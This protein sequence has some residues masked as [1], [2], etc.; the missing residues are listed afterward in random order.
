MK[1]ATRRTSTTL[2]IQRIF[3]LRPSAADQKY[4]TLANEWKRVLRLIF[5]IEYSFNFI[6]IEKHNYIFNWININ[7]KS[8]FL[9]WCGRFGA[10]SLISHDEWVSWESAPI[11][12]SQSFFHDLSIRVSFTSQNPNNF[13][14]ECN[15]DYFSSWNF[16]E[17]AYVCLSVRQMN[18][19]KRLNSC[20][21]PFRALRKEHYEER[22]D[23]FQINWN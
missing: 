1:N 11:E 9:L 6:S 22:L 2:V 23:T 12:Y 10:I 19:S 8:M 5:H 15:T 14:K 16:K 17:I 21:S 20:R 13:Y 18:S 3:G 4:V 7:V